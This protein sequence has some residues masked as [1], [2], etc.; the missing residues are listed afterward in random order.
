MRREWLWGLA[1][2]SAL[3]AGAWGGDG[4][5]RLAAP[6]YR[7]AA[8]L[9]ARGHPW[10]IE[11]VR[12]V[13]D[14]TMPGTVLRLIGDVRRQPGDPKAAAVVVARVTVGAVVQGPVVFWLLVLLWPARDAHQRWLRVALALPVFLGLEGVTTLCELLAP[15][16]DATAELAGQPAAVT[17]WDRWSKLV[18]AGGRIALAA[19]AAAVTV[20]AAQGLGRRRRGSGNTAVIA[21]SL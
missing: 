12:V 8:E 9:I 1:A 16:T 11:E 20:A 3:A 17:A 18:E 7:A 14:V 15:L 21:V 2:V 10:K 5:A 6:A 13:P 4:Y 19:A